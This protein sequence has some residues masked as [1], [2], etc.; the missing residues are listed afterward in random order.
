MLRAEFWTGIPAGIE[1]DKDRADVVFRAEAEEDVDALAEAVR[2]LLPEQVVKKD[3]HG[4]HADVFGP[5]ELEVDAL[6]VKGIGL[7]HFELIDGVVRQVV[8]ADRPRLLG[9]PGIGLFFAP[10]CGGIRVGGE[11]HGQEEKGGERSEET[12]LHRGHST[13]F[14]RKRLPAYALSKSEQIEYK[15]SDTF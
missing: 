13:G 7:P 12:H 11:S 2:I 8:A 15:G 10:A 3:T 1:E 5:A 4:V 14:L 9:I 6:R